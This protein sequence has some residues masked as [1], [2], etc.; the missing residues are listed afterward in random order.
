MSSPQALANPGKPLPVAVRAW[1]EAVGWGAI[2]GAGYG[3]AVVA[4]IGAFGVLEGGS[5]RSADAAGILVVSTTVALTWGGLLGAVYGTIA[6]FPMA[7]AMTALST[8]VRPERSLSLRLL[9][10]AGAFL[11]VS[12]V[13]GG[14]LVGLARGWLLTSELSNT[15]QSEGWSFWLAALAFAPGVIAAA[16][17]AWRTPSVVHPRTPATPPHLAAPERRVAAVAQLPQ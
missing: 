8:L 3:V 13:G 6:G 9:G 10:A 2:A 1:V 15:Y 14:L 12:A 17:F 16:I 5:G 11:A 7:V 4:V